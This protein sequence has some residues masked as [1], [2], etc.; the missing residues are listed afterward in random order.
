MKK[1]ILPKTAHLYIL[2]KNLISPEKFRNNKLK[3]KTFN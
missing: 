2:F 1:M 3:D